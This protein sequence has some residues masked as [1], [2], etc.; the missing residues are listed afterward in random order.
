MDFLIKAGVV[1]RLFATNTFVICDD[2]AR[3]V[4]TIFLVC[5]ICGPT[6]TL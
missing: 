6:V 3:D 5:T 2:A 4:H 1:K